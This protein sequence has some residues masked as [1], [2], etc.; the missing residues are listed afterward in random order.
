MRHI[1]TR[2]LCLT[3]LGLAAIAAAD[4][5][6]CPEHGSLSLQPARSW[7]HAFVSGNGRHGAMIWGTLP[8]ETVVA[9]HCR[10]FLP[11]GS[12]EIVPDLG[13]HLPEV[14]RLIREKGYGAAFRFMEEKAREQGWR[15]LVWTDPFHPGFELKVR[16]GGRPRTALDGSRDVYVDLDQAA[17]SSCGW[18]TARNGQSVM[19]RPLAIG[20]ITFPAGIGTHA[21]AEVVYQTGGKYRWL[22]FHAGISADMT[23]NGSAVVQVW[24]DG[25][26]AHETEVMRVRQQPRY[27]CL[28]IDGVKEARLAAT[29]AGN[30]IAADN[31]NFGNIRLSVGRDKPGEDTPTPAE[32]PALAGAGPA[33][34]TGIRDYFRSENFATGEVV[35]GWTDPQGAWRRRMFVSRADNAIVLSLTGPKGKL[36]AELAVPAITHKLIDSKM[37]A[38]KDGFV[39]HNVYVKGKGGYD[40]AVR[41][42]VRG[43]SA[44]CDGQRI[45]VTAAD[46]AVA[47]MRIQP[48]TKAED[49]APA[50][51]RQALAAIDADYDKLLAAHAKVHGELFGRAEVDLGGSAA[52]RQRPS[53][54]LLDQA[55]RAGTPGAALLEKMFDAGRYMFLCSA[56]ELAPNLQGIWTGTWQPAWSGDFTLDTNIQAAMSSALSGNMLEG[57][58]GYF[59]LIESFL[60]DCRENAKKMYGCRGI[61]TNSRASNNCLMLHWGGGWPGQFWTAGAG[62][63]AHWFH[64]YYL[65]TLDREFLARRAV[66]LLKEIALFYEDF[67]FLDETGRYRFSPSY[68]PETEMGDNATMD[69][70]VAREVLTNLIQGC[71]ELG[72]EAD[73]VTKWQAMLDKLPPYRINEQGELSEWALSGHREHYGHRHHSHLYPCFQS[74]EFDPQRTPE[75]WRAAQ[76]AV[77]KKIQSNGEQSSFGRIQAGLSAAFLRMPEEAFGRLAVM[78]TK[79]S[80]YAS[81]ITSHEPNQGIFNTDGNGGIPELLTSLL[82]FSRLG[83][84]DLL[85]ALP[86]ALPKGSLRGVLAR[87]GLRIDRLEWDIPAGTVRLEL[88]SRTDRPFTLRLPNTPALKSIR[89]TAGQA[90]LKDSPQGPNAREITPP[91]NQKIAIEIR[92]K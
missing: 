88:T 57:M 43:G 4:V 15:G 10:L 80:M 81:L 1:G 74:H 37:S 85:P 44:A 36:S 77:R 90:T 67:L 3:V 18:Q 24:L 76:A 72:I 45:T 55:A 64:D 69:L 46:E 29:D 58:E 27:V 11:L 47:V 25:R 53:E 35:V 62:W 73:N 89:L 71:R 13:R 91:A 22:T 48:W 14:R 52:D 70:A 61:L 12:R 78:A 16:Q 84:L 19:G 65:Y 31:V 54:D 50:A 23:E 32:Q 17:R 40:A 28:P 60:G 2:L 66:P 56:G 82:V 30:G 41:V 42:V 39:L 49:S 5:P 79:K 8:E 75:L 6:A 26:K 92:L 38:D 20:S 7:E 33:G 68:S 51:L 9:N 59:N 83:Q 63:L 21:P 87:G 86:A 34:D